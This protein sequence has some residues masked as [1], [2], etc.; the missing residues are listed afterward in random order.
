MEV[1]LAESSSYWMQPLPSSHPCAFQEQ[2]ELAPIT[3]YLVEGPDVLS[4]EANTIPEVLQCLVL[5]RRQ[6]GLRCLFSIT[7]ATPLSPP[8]LS[9]TVA[10]GTLHCLF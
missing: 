4:L 6:L 10:L 2:E 7:T 8:P 1:D 5:H 3:S 9:A